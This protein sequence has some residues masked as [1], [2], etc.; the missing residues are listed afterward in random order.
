VTAVDETW[1]WGAADVAEGDSGAWETR[2]DEY[3]LAEA[4]GEGLEL[5]EDVLELGEVLREALRE[6]YTDA[7]PEEMEDTLSNVFELMTPAE[8]FNFT[9]ALRQVETGAAQA[10]ADP[11]VG[12]FATAA[13]PLA[14]AAVGTAYGGPAGTA[15]GSGLGGAAAKALSGAKPAPPTRPGAPAMPSLPTS[16]V[17][18]GSSAAAKG[19]ILT[20]QPDVLKSLLALSLGEHGR[21][22]VGGVPVG[23]V[24]NLLSTIFGQAA[25]D[26]DE[27]L[28]ADEATNRY[29]LE[30]QGQYQPDPA[31]PAD[32][33]DA[34]YAALLDAENEDL[35]EAVGEW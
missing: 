12:Q 3:Y 14:G 15:I 16:P 11:A 6:D 18:A 31:A 26:A 17:A 30:S 19:L 4:L 33:A 29:L 21:K 7:P 25:A 27:L 8:S 9:K 20:Q 28:Y 1:E 32:R 5:D 2:D 13:L 24:M 22:S 35:T 10:L 23:A 34:L